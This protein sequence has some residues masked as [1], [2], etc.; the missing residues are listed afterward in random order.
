MA[1]VIRRSNLRGVAY[2]SGLG[3]HTST[4]FFT[5]CFGN[6]MR[7]RAHAGKRSNIYD[8]HP[9]VKCEFWRWSISQSKWVLIS[10]R[11]LERETTLEYQVR[12]SS[13]TPS[14]GSYNYSAAY[15]GTDSYLFGFRAETISGKRSVCSDRIIMYNIGEDVTYDDHVKGKKIYCKPN[16]GAYYHVT[17]STSP[18][19][20][21]P[22]QPG[23][24]GTT[25]QRGNYITRAD[26][27][28]MVS[29]R[30]AIS[31]T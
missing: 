17:S 13:D 18:T 20:V 1:N 21:N 31:F 29:V 30:S 24:Y 8:S 14:A 27:P 19:S 26:I 9:Q 23:S 16:H 6:V 5:Y 4:S 7:F 15:N 22:D 10:E 28:R 2:D 25:N 11:T 3:E 12:V